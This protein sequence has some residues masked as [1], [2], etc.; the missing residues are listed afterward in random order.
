MAAVTR[1][2]VF[3]AADELDAKG[4][5]P[6]YQAVRKAIGGGSYTTLKDMLTEWKEQ[7]AAKTRQ[8]ATEPA[9]EALTAYIADFGAQV[10]ALAL[11]AAGKRFVADR[12]ALEAA[13]IELEQ[14]RNEALEAADEATAELEQEKAKVAALIDA[15]AAAK[16]ETEA[17]KTQLAGISE[18]A[19]MA[20][21]RAVE[22]EKRA[23]DLNAELERQH[24]ANA[25]LVKALAA[26]AA[27]KKPAKGE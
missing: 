3:A 26:A 2:R 7:R 24:Q 22:L 23:G 25:E 14:E 18:R 16:R 17:V 12:E 13:R 9:P 15:E 11:E 6:T 20:E 5:N 10:W 8:P 1:E 19:T 4:E 21:T 27:G